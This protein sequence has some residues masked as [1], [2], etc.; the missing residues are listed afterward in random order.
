MAAVIRVFI[1]TDDLDGAVNRIRSFD[2]KTTNIVVHK[3]GG[4]CCSVTDPLGN[5]FDLIDADNC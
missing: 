3:W 1:E 2:G 5:N 4:R